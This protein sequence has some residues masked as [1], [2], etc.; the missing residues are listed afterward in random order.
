MLAPAGQS[1]RP[2]KS[3]SYIFL[4][5]NVRRGVQS[6]QEKK[7]AITV[8][9]YFFTHQRGSEA[10][11]LP[12][13]NQQLSRNIRPVMFDKACQTSE[14]TKAQR[15]LPVPMLHHLPVGY[16][17]FQHVW[18][19]GFFLRLRNTTEDKFSLPNIIIVCMC[20]CI[21]VCVEM[22][23]MCIYVCTHMHTNA[24]NANANAHTHTHTCTY[25]FYS[26]GYTMMLI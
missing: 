21:Y 16:K 20:I 10:Y 26:L 1:F 6:L 19:S 12:R 8:G 24:Q 25:I 18:S 15:Y 4:S 13:R 5:S 2:T 23:S 9:S 17:Y 11:L 3:F 7:L 14:P 22:P